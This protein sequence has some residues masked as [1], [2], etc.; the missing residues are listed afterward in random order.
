[1]NQNCRQEIFHT[2]LYGKELPVFYFD[3]IDSTNEEA[4]RFLS[5]GYAKQALF[6]AESQTAG[7]GRRGR[8][9]YSP[10]ETGLYMSLLFTTKEALEDVIFV[11]T[12]ASVIVARAIETLTGETVKIK[13]VNDLYLRNR[14]VCGILTEAVL[15]TP[16][17]GETG[18]VVGIGINV[19]TEHFPEQLAETAGSLGRKENADVTK[20]RLTEEITKGL[21]SFLENVKDRT[22]MEEYRR[23]SMVIGQ[24][25]TC[26]DGAGSYEA[27]ALDIDE[28]GGLVVETAEGECKVLHTGEIT[29]RL[30][31][32]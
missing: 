1:M 17:C 11:T 3:E 29:I 22:C 21:I 18:I 19:T 31:D 26:F 25:I 23:R 7:K 8:S 16:Q 20:A 5:Q 12:A 32:S 4:K 9:F 15:P 6:V 28:N 14:K 10:A 2:S 24:S 13:W 30:C 27:F